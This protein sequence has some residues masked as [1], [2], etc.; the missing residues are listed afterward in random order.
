MFLSNT[1]GY[2]AKISNTAG[3]YLCNNIMYLN[4]HE[5]KIPAGF[6]HIPASH[7]LA[8]HSKKEMASWSDEDLLKAVKVIVGT[9]V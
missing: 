9:L 6:I 1:R 2:P 4:L 5:Y 7:S 3:T 8:I